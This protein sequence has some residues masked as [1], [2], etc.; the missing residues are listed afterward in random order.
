VAYKGTSIYKDDVHMRL[1]SILLFLSFG[2]FLHAALAV[3]SLNNNV[4][5][6]G[7]ITLTDLALVEG[8]D[9]VLVFLYGSEG[10]GTA[11]TLTVDSN[12]AT[13]L[14]SQEAPNS[15]S[16]TLT[17]IFAYALGNV[18]AGATVDVE[19][20]NGVSQN[21]YRVLQLTGATQTF[22]LGSTFWVDSVG[23]DS[24]SSTLNT[25]V[26]DVAAGSVL[27]T[28]AFNEANH[29]FSANTG[30]DSFQATLNTLDN[31]DP[32]FFTGYTEDVSGMV[33]N[34]ITY[35]NS[36]SSGREFVYASVAIA[37]VPEPSTLVLVGA[38]FG[39]LLLFRKRHS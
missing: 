35:G 32:S 34:S 23:A 18:S 20:S 37:A 31:R 11:P 21:A 36:L 2:S 38:A 27:I 33:N 29:N 17:R 1:F 22:T 28:S 16:A 19:L 30:Y 26:T 5:V 15:G 3:T 14:V 13:L 4:N 25:S 9:S 10:V 7:D 8:T 6:N 39:S 12:A 24:G